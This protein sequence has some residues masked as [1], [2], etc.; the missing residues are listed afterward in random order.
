MQRG[1][2]R[3][4]TCRDALAGSVPLVPLRGPVL[5][6]RFDPR[7][8]VRRRT[9]DPG[10]RPTRAVSTC[11]SAPCP[12][13]P[14]TT[15]GPGRAARRGDVE[16]QL[17]GL[18][19][20][21]DQRARR[22]RDGPAGR[23][24]ARR[25]GRQAWWSRLGA[26]GPLAQ[27]AERPGLEVRAASESRPRVRRTAGRPPSSAHFSSWKTRDRVSSLS[28][29]SSPGAATR[30]SVHG[31]GRCG[32]GSS[33][34]QATYTVIRASRSAAA[35]GDGPVRR[36]R[37]SCRRL[38]ARHRRGGRRRRR[39]RG[40]VRRSRLDPSPGTGRSTSSWRSRA[41]PPL[42]AP[43]MRL[44]SRLSSS[45]G[46]RTRRSSTSEPNPGASFSKRA[47]IRS[48]NRSRSS[49]SQAPRMPSSPASPR[50]FLGHVGVGPHR[51]G[52]GG[53]PRRV[54]G[55]H[56][57]GQHE[58]P[59]RDQPGARPGPS[60]RPCRRR[61]RR[62]ARSR[63]PWPVRSPRAPVRRGPSRPSPSTGRAG[64][65]A[66]RGARGRVR[67]RRPAGRRTASARR[68]WPRPRARP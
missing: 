10:P 14:I 12:T 13:Y 66:C 44:A 51:L 59:G 52:A 62:C 27:P 18:V 45:C 20:S 41:V 67:R 54:G 63:V 6:R 60:P 2:G 26:H 23:L 61:C 50:R 30:S 17:T 37:R 64:S 8:G 24:A 4:R 1:V 25:A 11:C 28:T 48:A 57:P 32:S 16:L 3:R 33:E 38:R 5:A 34:T 29:R 40:R 31:P 49:W 7:P 68:P 53:R 65:G 35:P 19:G 9:G 15:V 39:G 42:M 43:P 22:V 21:L 56:L 36:G 46:P 47:C 55:G 58:R